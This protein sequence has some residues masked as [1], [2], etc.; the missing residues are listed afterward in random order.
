MRSS[1]Y[2]CCTSAD[3]K[4][5]IA[6]NRLI[7]IILFS[8]LPVVDIEISNQRCEF[9]RGSTIAYRSRL[10]IVTLILILMGLLWHWFVHGRLY[11]STVETPHGVPRARDPLIECLAP[12]WD[13]YIYYYIPGNK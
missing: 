10:K 1:A 9:S 5:Q 8:R 12:C 7:S 13:L 4:K 11:I 6:S 2:N 3:L